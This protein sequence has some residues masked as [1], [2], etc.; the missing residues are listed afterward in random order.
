M[1]L[2]RSCTPGFHNRTDDAAKKNQKNENQ[3]STTFV[4]YTRRAARH[5]GKTRRYSGCTV[6]ARGLRIYGD[7]GAAH[8]AR[9]RAQKHKPPDITLP[10]S[11]PPLCVHFS[12]NFLL[13][14]RAAFS[15]NSLRRRRARR[16]TCTRRLGERESAPP[17]WRSRSGV[18][19]GC[20][21]VA[22]M[23]LIQLHT[24]V[25]VQPFTRSGLLL[26]RMSR[27]L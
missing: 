5:H 16:E 1:P 27:S 18:R 15:N 4:R 8:G 9:R 6:R 22:G 24:R 2:R 3:H 12:P 17:C 21:P 23:L 13:C 10:P 25:R 20:L 19:R 14:G 26:T 11:L 7:M